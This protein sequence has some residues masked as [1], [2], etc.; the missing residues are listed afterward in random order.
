MR[1]I[2][3]NILDIAENSVKAHASVVEIGVVAEGNILTVTIDDD[4]DGMDEK[5]LAK[6]TDPFTTTRTTR[7]V[8]MG[9]PLFKMAAEMA[10][11]EFEISSKKGIG[12]SVKATFAIDNIDRAPLG[13]LG[14][15]VTALI[16][17][18]ENVEFVV[19]C[20]VDGKEFVFDTRELKAQLQSTF[21]YMDEKLYNSPEI[22]SFVR[23][24]INENLID[25]GGAKL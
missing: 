4:G 24:M 25:I 17:E 16:F 12:T 15:T 2:A 1:E 19:K 11:G 22:V 8:G 5:F 6:V 18:E 13:N 23:D 10:G 9:I 14:E 20:S 3:L 7:K 21:G